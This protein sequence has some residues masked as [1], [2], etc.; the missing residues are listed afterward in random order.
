M[1]KKIAYAVF[2]TTDSGLDI[3]VKG[4]FGNNKEK[5]DEWA[6]HNDDSNLDIT[7]KEDAGDGYNPC[8]PNGL[9]VKKVEY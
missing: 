5:A 4:N 6:H 1:K 2:T 8:Y 9:V 3:I 7:Q